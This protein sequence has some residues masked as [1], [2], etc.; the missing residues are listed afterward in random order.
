MG[1]HDH[2]KIHEEPWFVDLPLDTQLLVLG[3]LC[4]D[5]MREFGFNPQDNYEKRMRLLSTLTLK[6]KEGVRVGFIQVIEM[7]SSLRP[8]T[9]FLV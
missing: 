1:L 4:Y 7:F 8:Q 6:K 3:H 2:Y 9:L 5:L